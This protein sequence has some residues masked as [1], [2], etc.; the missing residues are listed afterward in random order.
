MAT[1]NYSPLLSGLQVLIGRRIVVLRHE[2]ER[3]LAT[4]GA[5]AVQTDV[6]KGR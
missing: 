3:M 5:P 4:S 6:R 2:L 1:K